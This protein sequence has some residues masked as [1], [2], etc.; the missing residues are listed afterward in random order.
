MKHPQKS[1]N[2]FARLLPALRHSLQGLVAAYQS[3][4]AV[5]QEAWA[6]VVLVPLAL[7]LGQTPMQRLLLAGVVIFVIIAEL[8]N[9]AIEA[10]VDRISFEHHPLSKQAKDIGSAAV[11]LSLMLAASTWGVVVWERFA[12]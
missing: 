8:L 6:A 9:S 2:G 5:R 3:E 12:G 11:L 10:V 7:W 1:R 4:S